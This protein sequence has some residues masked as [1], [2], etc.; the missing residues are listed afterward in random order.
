MEQSV[1]GLT[2]TDSGDLGGPGASGGRGQLCYWTFHRPYYT[3][4]G[5]PFECLLA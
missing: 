1:G 4:V 5:G 2:T 3:A